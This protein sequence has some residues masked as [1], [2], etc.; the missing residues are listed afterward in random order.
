M[1]GVDYNKFK[2]QSTFGRIPVIGPLGKILFEKGICRGQYF[3]GWIKELLKQ[4]NVE[5]FND[6]IIEE[7]KDDLQ[8]RYKLNV[9]V[10]DISR[11][12][13]LVLPQDIAEYGVNPESLNV[14][15]AV[16]MS[17]SIPFFYKPVTLRNVK[18]NELS[19]IVDGG[20]LSNFPVWLFDTQGSIPEW[21][22]FGFKLVEPEEG[23]PRKIRGPISML[24][25]LFST[26]MEAHDARY[27]K[28]E[29]FVRTIPIPT[30][31]VKTTEFDIKRERSEALYQSGRQAGEKFLSTWN[32]KEYIEKYR[33]VAPQRRTV[34][35]WTDYVYKE[36][37]EYHS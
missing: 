12:R 22:T 33:K 14:A 7:F 9:I 23:I 32:F 4:K 2:D 18:A 20:L 6:L 13:L 29:N 28:E 11:G 35:I 3:E 24:G 27:I 19:Y 8:Y 1:A 21:P 5:T 10:S 36:E 17:M 25:A 34:R 16:R 15:W 31:G 26:M 37:K 30:L